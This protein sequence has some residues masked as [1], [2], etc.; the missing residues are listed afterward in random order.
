MALSIE[1]P[2]DILTSAR[3]TP[4]E[5]RVELAIALYSARRLSVG[6]ARELAEMSL[7]E[8]RQILAARKI[9]V[10]LDSEDFF[11]EID[12]LNELGRL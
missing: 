11:E 8:F 2:D 6:K 12:T 10:D 3:M 5:M 1:I 9:P 7:F 4:A